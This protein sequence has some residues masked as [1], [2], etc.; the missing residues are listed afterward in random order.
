MKRTITNKK[1]I[2]SSILSLILC[3][4]LIVGGTFALF[5][6]ESKTNIAVNSGKVE[7]VATL[8]NLTLYSPTKISADGTSI[9]DEN[10]AAVGLN[11]KNGGTASLEGAK[12]VLD[13]MTPG[14]YATFDIV[15]KNN[16]NVSVNYRTAFSAIADTGLFAGLEVTVDGNSFAGSQVTDWSTLAPNTQPSPNTLHVKVELP[17]GAGNEYQ[18]KSVALVFAVY[19]V[20][21]NAELTSFEGDEITL[22][23]AADLSYFS[24]LVNGGNSFADKT[25]KLG[26]DIDMEGMAYIPAGGV[27]SYPSI[28]FAGTFDGKGHTISNLVTS[29]FGQGGN[30]SAGLFG[31]ITGVVKNVNLNKAT[32]TSSH[33]AGGIAGYSSAN[34]TMT[35]EN[36]KVTNSTITSAPELLADGTYDNGDKVGGIIGYMASGDDVIGCTVENTAIKGYRDIGGIAG[37]AMGTL[38]NNAV[39]NVTV[40]IDNEHNYKSYK[41]EAE[42]DCG[43]VVGQ[44]VSDDN[45]ASATLNN[46]KVNGVVEIATQ[47]ELAEAISGAGSE[48]VTL[49]LSSRDFTLPAISG[50]NSGIS[51]NITFTGTKATQIALK[52]KTNAYDATVCFDGVTIIGETESG[53]Y[54]N[55][56]TNQLDGSTKVIYTDCDIKDLITTYG[57]SDFTSCKFYNTLNDQYSAFCY[58]GT[59]FNFTNCVFNTECSKAIKLYNESATKALTLNVTGCTFNTDTVDKAPI[60]LDSQK[61]NE[62]YNYTANISDCT[63]TGA[64]TS[65]WND[66]STKSIVYVDGYAAS[67]NALYKE[68]EEASENDTI[69]INGSFGAIKL[70]AGTENLTIKALDSRTTMGSLNL[71]GA[72][73]VVIDGI[74]FDAAKAV[75]VFDNKSG[76]NKDTNCDAS[77]YDYRWDGSSFG[78]ASEDITI[79]NCIFTGAASVEG[80][81]GYTAI[82][83]NE[84]GAGTRSG[85]ITVEGCTF[86]CNAV[87]YIYIQYVKKDSTTTIENNIFGG[88]SCK[89]AWAAVAVQQLTGGKAVINNNTFNTWDAEDSAIKV[90]T[91]SGAEAMAAAEITNNTFN[92]GV[93]DNCCVVEIRRSGNTGHTV[94]DNTYNISGRTLADND[95]ATT[96]KNVDLTSTVAIRYRDVT[97]A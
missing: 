60:E 45:T 66:K 13:K 72:K 12:L 54:S 49:L 25:V 83:I 2:L 35:I 8:D 56:Y 21:A 34:T 14:D 32:I 87:S 23:S 5:T 68:I 36:C 93:D 15:M 10:N 65:L 55:Y 9:V 39:T 94:S 41:L 40:S 17:T 27:N 84:V 43:N 52:A 47:E 24:Q 58:G 62:G 30:A 80:E 11:F 78:A 97:T 70:P 3:I 96:D 38:E 44:S 19:A 29:S 18:D 75:D 46:N 92:G 59:E 76:S 69:I 89:V 88:G 28:T 63:I 1:V 6:S 20:Q 61:L 73:N 64:Y 67:E 91:M 31:S 16:S 53:D 51:K 86:N 57:N 95:S 4:S 50:A 37:Y 81:A 71:N 90:S 7:F 22:Y 42:H 48:A 82:N 85:N 33:Y 79:K 26:N 74:T 77:I